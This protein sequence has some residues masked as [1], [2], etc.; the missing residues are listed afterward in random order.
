VRVVAGELK[1]RRLVAPDGRDTRPTTDRTR[2]AVFNALTSADLVVGRTYADLFAG[3]GALG[4][5]ALSRG[6]D[7]CTFVERDPRAL[8]ALRENISTLGL[9]ARATVVPADA[10]SI[11]PRLERCD[12]AVIDPPYGFSGWHDLL[13]SLAVTTAVVEAGEPITVPPQGWTVL[14]AR[15]YGRTHVT[16]LERGDPGTVGA[17]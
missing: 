11:G 12:V 9:E 8:R 17:P 5:E 15:R 14:R 1:G 7:H 16:I 6:A 3:T 13:G 10:T 4:I 2:E